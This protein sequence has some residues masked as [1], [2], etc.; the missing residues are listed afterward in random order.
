MVSL[1]VTNG[2]RAVAAHFVIRSLRRQAPFGFPNALHLA[3]V[4]L[5]TAEWRFEPCAEDLF[6]HGLRRGTQAEAQHVGVVPGARAL[7]CLGA[8]CISSLL[9]TKPPRVAA[10]ET[11]PRLGREHTCQAGSGPKRLTENLLE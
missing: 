8:W 2:A 7:R 1:G 6:R 3:Q 4:P 10:A 5:V 11:I 9:D